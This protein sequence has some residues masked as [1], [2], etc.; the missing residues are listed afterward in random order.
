MKARSNGPAS[1][2]SPAA[3]ASSA[4]ALTTV[5]RS[6]AMPGLAPPAAR[7]VGPL[8]VR[9]DRHDRPV[10]RLAERQPQRRVAVR[11]PDLDDPAPAAGEHGQDAAGVAIDDR[12]AGPAAPPPRSRPAPAGARSA[13][14]SIQS[15]STASGI[16]PRSFLLMRHSFRQ[17]SRP[18]PKYSPAARIVPAAIDPT[19]MYSRPVADSIDRVRA[20]WTDAQDTTS[21]KTR[22][23]DQAEPDEERPRP[24]QRGERRD[25]GR[26]GAGRDPGPEQDDLEG[27]DGEQ[28]PGKQDQR[29]LGELRRDQVPVAEDHRRED[30][31]DGGAHDSELDEQGRGRRALPPPQASAPKT[32]VAPPRPGPPTRAAHGR[33][34][35]DATGDQAGHGQDAERSQGGPARAVPGRVDD[36]RR[37]AQRVRQRAIGDPGQEPEAD[38]AGRR[39]AQ[40]AGGRRRSPAEQDDRRVGPERQAGQHGPVDEGEVLG[41]LRRGHGASVAALLASTRRCSAMGLDRDTTFTWYGHSCVEV[42]TPGGKVILIDPWFGNPR[43]PRTADIDRALRPPAGD[44]R[45]RRPHGRARSR[46]RAGSGRPGRASTR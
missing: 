46:W 7:E 31:A 17:T 15:R 14:D 35:R 42:R 2:G 18:A 6:S 30:A 22:P 21:G 13:S 25:V 36:D 5:I 19:L 39:E 3:K 12:D 24:D 32:S 28:D 1:A 9:I 4:G 11:R 41:D 20:V 40:V 29:R 23:D 45:P 38:R 44:P 10:G 26:P 8:A 43:S 37:V 27:D 34:G 33:R 16:Q